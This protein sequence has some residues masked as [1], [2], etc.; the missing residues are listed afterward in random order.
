MASFGLTSGASGLPVSIKIRVD[1]GCFHREHSPHAYQI[2]DDHLRHLDSHRENFRF[3]EHESGPEILAYVAA[4]TV[5]VGLTKSII[6]LVVTVVKARAEGIKNGDH[7]RHDLELIVRRFDQKGEYAEEKI[8]RISSNEPI[9]A[10]KITAAL[11]NRPASIATV[12]PVSK[13]KRKKR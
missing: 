9:D 13:M 5:G 1:S 2:I 8:L 11:E 10:A 4:A 6:D 3:V 12:P 7:P